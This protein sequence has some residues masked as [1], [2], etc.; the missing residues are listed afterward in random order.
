MNRA[1][2]R[3]WPHN[4]QPSA[5]HMWKEIRTGAATGSGHVAKCARC[6]RTFIER[7]DTRG[8]VYCYP[9]P[10]WM[11]ANPGDDGA[12]GTGPYGT[13][14]GE[15]G[16]PLPTRATDAEKREELRNEITNTGDC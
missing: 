15:Y 2:L 9:T 5:L 12:L 8:P 16:R 6:D 3:T 1:Q 13:R 11:A 7:A 10:A 14:C 4:N